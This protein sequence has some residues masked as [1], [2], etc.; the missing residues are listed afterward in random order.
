[1]TWDGVNDKI[2]IFLCRFFVD[3]ALWH[4][5][6]IGQGMKL[7]HNSP[8]HHGGW[9]VVCI[10]QNTSLALSHWHVVCMSVAC[11]LSCLNG[12]FFVDLSWV[13]DKKNDE[14]CGRLCHEFWG[15]DGWGRK[16][17]VFVTLPLAY[18]RHYSAAN[19]WQVL[20]QFSDI[21]LSVSHC[22]TT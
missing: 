11:R 9:H 6:M 5:T 4:G 1:M 17:T 12:W 22:T 10:S 16:T 21:T 18:L 3:I 19:P 14:T 13:L 2:N 8:M 20:W 7:C 15:S